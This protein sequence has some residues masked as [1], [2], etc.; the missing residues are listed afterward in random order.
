MS[1]G[2]LSPIRR[3]NGMIADLYLELVE[4][5]GHDDAVHFIELWQDDDAE[6]YADEMTTRW[7]GE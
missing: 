3:R 7:Q 5:L 1:S 6:Q 4:M 2:A